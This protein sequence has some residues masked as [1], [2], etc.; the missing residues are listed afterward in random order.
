MGTDAAGSAID[1]NG[2][3]AGFGDHFT[4]HVLDT[5]PAAGCVQNRFPPAACQRDAAA[6]RISSYRP[7]DASK[8]Q[9]AARGARIHLAL[10]IAD[11]D[12]TARRAQI[13]IELPRQRHAVF[14]LSQPGE[15]QAFAVPARTAAGPSGKE[16]P[17]R[18]SQRTGFP[19]VLEPPVHAD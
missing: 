1:L 2:A 16:A 5:D 19:S 13:D 9:S 10:E 17:E 8:V 12:R 15:L 18:P 6:G 4:G 14:H 7:I 11:R 3:P